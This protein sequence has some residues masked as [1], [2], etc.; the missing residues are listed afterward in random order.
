MQKNFL[1]KNF[2]HMLHGGDYNADQWVHRPDILE[3]DMRLFQKANCNEAS[4]GI[5]S[6]ASLEPEEGKFDFSFLDKTMDDIYT[7]GGR[8]LLATPSAARPV[9]LSEK[10]PEVLRWSNTFVQNHYGKR[11]NHCY[12]S[13]IYREKVRIINEK[14]AERYKDHPALIGWHIGNEYNGKCYCPN[15]Q[16]AFREFLKKKYGTLAQLNEQ[17]WTGFWAHTYTSWE[18]IEPPSPIGDEA[19]HGRNVDWRRFC[20]EQTYDFIKAEIAAVKKY[21]PNIPVTSN[22]MAFH[23]DLDYISMCEDL[24]FASIDVYPPYRGSDKTD[25]DLAKQYGLYYDLTR[26]FKHKP[27]ILMENA[28]GLVSWQPYNKLKRPGMD[29]QEAMQAI[30]HGSDSVLYFQFRKSRGGFEKWHGAII[31]HEGSE[32]TR[33]FKTV[34][35]IGARLK[36]LDRIVGTTTNA[37]VALLYDWSNSWALNDSK[38]FQLGDKK[39][40]PTV[41]KFYNPL[42]DRGINTDVIGVRDIFENYKVIIAPML[43]SLSSETAQKLKAFVKNGGIL[44]STYMLGMVNE[45]DL[46]Y[47]GGFPGSGLREVFGVWNEEIDTLYPD[48]KNTVRLNNG[49]IVDAIDYCEQIHTEGAEVLARYDSDF[50]QGNPA[51]TVNHYGDGLAYYIAFR[52][53]GDFTDQ[54][55][56][57]ILTEAGIVCDFDGTL[58]EGVSVHSRTDGENNFIFL[59]NFSY[60]PQ[61]VTTSIVWTDLETGQSL[62]GTIRLQPLQTIILT[63]RHQE[64]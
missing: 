51:A 42:W 4:V 41:Q 25:I 1:F 45:N 50:Y 39:L 32:N 9:W 26:S 48:E 64:Y 59:Q 40:L 36:G 27:F 57:Q 63:K 14:L 6:W 11:H 18:Q 60:D 5:F 49:N 21:T 35:E 46:C 30:A 24:D 22:Y 37:P 12:T 19:I 44:L 7:A 16:N 61:T 38:S 31:D 2:H 28:P 13:P 53:R 34:S 3:E 58:P 54:L 29:M 55:V 15:C 8:V 56:G 33:V 43:Y 17:W 47:L 62:T 20:S 23:D 52:D 10:Y